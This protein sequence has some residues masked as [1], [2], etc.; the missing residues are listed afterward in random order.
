MNFKIKFGNLVEAEA[1]FIVNASNTELTLGSGVSYAFS[2]HCGGDIY[3]KE[4][5]KIKKSVGI[6]K[7]GDVIVSSP[8]SATNF[9]YALHVAVMNY[10]EA[11]QTPSPTYQQMQSALNSMLGIIEEIVQSE[12]IEKPRIAMPLL[13]CGVGGLSKEKIFL[14][15]KSIF[16]KSELDLEVLIYFHNKKD[17]Y[18]FAS[19]EIQN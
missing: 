17:Y 15:I 4:L 11:S 3:Q 1:T 6:I 12:K 2:Q 19:K 14:I 13:G 10:S 7:Q 9:K 8:G 16:K 18:E 5:Y